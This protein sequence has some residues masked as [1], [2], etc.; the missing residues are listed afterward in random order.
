MRKKFLN[1]GGGTSIPI[2]NFQILQKPFFLLRIP[3]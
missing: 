3:L 1:P 2:F